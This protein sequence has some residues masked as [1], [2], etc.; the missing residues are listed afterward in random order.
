MSERR[1]H[2]NTDTLKMF[3]LIV[4]KG[5]ITAAA[6]E[7]GYAQSN[8]STKVHQLEQQLNTKLFYRN[9]RGITLTESGQELFDQA[10]NIVNL[11]EQ[12]IEQIQHPNHI[13]GKLRIGTLQTAASTFLPKTLASYHEA[14]PHVELSI[15]TGTTLASINSILNYEL[16]GAIVGG[17]VNNDDLISIE[18]MQEDL[19]LITSSYSKQADLV[20]SPLLV[21]P[22]GC[23]YRK[24]LERWLDSKK[25]TFPQPIEF[26]YL[27]AIIASVSAGLGI[28]VLPKKVI[29]PFIDE[30]TVTAIDLPT[31]FSKLTISFIYRKNYVVGKSLARFIKQVKLT[32]Q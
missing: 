15:K 9:R 1:I 29:Q 18:L 7:L 22:V 5:S 27:N 11:T 21:F 31:K 14:N 20:K 6:K 3:I 25:V 8:I 23:A 4:Q 30:G 16:D 2:M 13:V 32:S 10:V 26:D 28:S 19:C 17:E 12:T 24:T